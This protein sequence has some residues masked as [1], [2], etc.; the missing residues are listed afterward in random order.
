MGLALLT[1]VQY[2]ITR[3]QSTVIAFV[4]GG[5]YKAGNGYSMVG[6]HTDSPCLRVCCTVHIGVSILIM[7]PVQ[8]KPKSA[9]TKSGYLSVGLSDVMMMWVLSWV[10]R[11]GALWWRSVAHMVMQLC[12]VSAR[13][14]IAGSTAI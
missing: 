11:R 7:S 10:H 9:Q 12:F 1:H 13:L 8:V 5:Q 6:A 3:N 4:V 14:M 2:Y